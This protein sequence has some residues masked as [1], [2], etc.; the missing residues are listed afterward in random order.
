MIGDKIY[1]YEVNENGAFTIYG[2]IGM[3]QYYLKKP[4]AIKSYMDKV[5]YENRN[6]GVVA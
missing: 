4:D 1:G 2:V 5:F 6:R 3:K